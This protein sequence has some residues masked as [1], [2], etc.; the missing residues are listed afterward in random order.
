MPARID[1][2]RLPDVSGSL[3]HIATRSEIPEP[4]DLRIAESAV[5][6]FSIAFLDLA[7]HQAL[8]LQNGQIHLNA[9]P[10]R[11]IGSID[12]GAEDFAAV[13]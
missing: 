1:G 6:G 3:R 11:E 12:Y 8:G 9:P 4:H 7:Q 10:S 13:Q 5:K 2:T